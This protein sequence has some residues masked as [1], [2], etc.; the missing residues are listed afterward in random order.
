MAALTDGELMR[1]KRKRQKKEAAAA[2]A[3]DG[4]RSAA[5]GRRIFATPE[6]PD[7]GNDDDDGEK[8]AQLIP[9]RFF[10]K[11]RLFCNTR[12]TSSP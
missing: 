6:L 12:W 5:R 4:G 8:C 11:L 10:T 2:A 7:I 1:T 3:A 9:F